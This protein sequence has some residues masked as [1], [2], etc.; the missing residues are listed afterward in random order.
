[1]KYQRSNCF[2]FNPHEFHS[3]TSPGIYPKRQYAWSQL[4]E[5][6]GLEEVKVGFFVF[7]GNEVVWN[8]IFRI[9]ANIF[10]ISKIYRAFSWL[11]LSE[12][13]SRLQSQA[14]I[15]VLDILMVER[16]YEFQMYKNVSLHKKP[17]K[18]LK[19]K[20]KRNRDCHRHMIFFNVT[21][22]SRNFEATFENSS[23]QIQ[24]WE[25]P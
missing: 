9:W 14:Y 4:S 21:N 19:S 8:E 15:S 22:H 6:F 25:L 11:V 10:S 7:R 13:K 16:W 5:F 17:P 12:T 1:M 20:E 18:F 23:L 3:L 24:N 2:K